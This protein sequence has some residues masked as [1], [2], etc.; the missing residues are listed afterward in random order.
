MDPKQF[1]YDEYRDF[2]VYQALAQIEPD[3]N[4]KKTLT[5]LS[6]H[7]RQ[8][9]IFWSEI[10]GQKDFRVGKA[11]LLLY[12]LARKILGLTFTAK[13]L[14]MHEKKSIEGYQNFAL[15]AAPEIRQKLKDIIQN[16]IDHE[17]EHISQI[18]EEKIQ[19]I[20]SIILGLNDALIEL[21]GALVGF[22]FALRE[23]RLIVVTG[24][25]TG[26]AASLSMAASAFMQA[27][28]EPDKNPKK[29]AFYTG[30]SYIIVVMLLVL[31]FLLLSSSIT[32]MTIMLSVAILIITFVSFYVSVLFERNFVK[33]LSIMLLFS[34]GV[35]AITFGI[36]QLAVFLL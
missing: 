23:P 4:L 15:T 17:R 33:Q 20:S 29:A 22:T 26:I 35:A 31:P 10:S 16:D 1:A 6:E 7:E 30:I 9:Y 24:L 25:I 12:K 28:Y 11:Y 27:R 32:A 21:S 34:L 36:G 2:M 18:H 14:E 5:E 19:F 8:H 3:L 13:F